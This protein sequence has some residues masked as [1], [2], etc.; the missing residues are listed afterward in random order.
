MGAPSC[1]TAAF[2]LVLASA[3]GGGAPPDMAQETVGPDEDRVAQQLVDI[4]HAGQRSVAGDGKVLRGLHAHPHA[5][6]RATLEPDP[7]RPSETRFGVF[8]EDHTW[9]AWVRISN[10]S[11]NSKDDR[12]K[13]PRGF[14]IKLTAVPGPK[15]L[16]D[17]STTQD[18]MLVNSPVFTSPD[19]TGFVDLLAALYQ[20]KA[21]VAV[22]A[23]FH[24]VDAVRLVTALGG[25]VPSML[26]LTYFSTTPYRLGP[27]DTSLARAVK[28][29]AKPCQD[30]VTP[31][32]ANPAADY[33]AQDVVQRLKDGDACFELA[34][35]F[36]KD[37]TSTPIEDA[38]V[39]WREAD[40]PFVK[41]ATLRIP[42]Q[43]FSSPGQMDFCDRLSF[44]PWH[45]LR[46][47]QPLGGIN[48]VRRVAYEA[49]TNFRHT[50][51]NLPALEPSGTESFPDA[52]TAP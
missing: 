8:Q 12:E 47:H 46:E 15:L 48:R 20:G 24:P 2:L 17:E 11:E 51:N 19:A 32:P 40:A 26:D 3:C 9:N 36:Q 29:R 22:W 1:W 21:A 14:A 28:Y 25:D 18:L 13:S 44:T 38:T 50:Q 42:R 4:I 35:Q 23:L 16:R 34:V 39:E 52:T 45:S 6:V 49:S 43:T 10:G 7:S 30:H 27:S 5:C 37:A 31:M 33:L 41:V